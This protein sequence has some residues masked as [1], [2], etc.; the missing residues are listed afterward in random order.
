MNTLRN[1][2]QEVIQDIQHQIISGK[3]K[4]LDKLKP[5]R[6]L[7]TNYQASRSVV[8]SAIH[9][10]S[11]KGYV[12]V[13]PR[14]GVVINDFLHNGT[15]DVVKDIYFSDNTELKAVIIK[16]VMKV[17]MMA[18]LE[19]ISLITQ[20][21]A[22]NLAS[23]ETIINQEMNWL[24]AKNKTI[25]AIAELDHLFHNTLIAL[26]GNNV[27]HLVYNSFEAIE[28]ALII[29]FYENSKLAFEV[30]KMH[31][32]LL[33]A[34]KESDFEYAKNLW[35]KVLMQGEDEILKKLKT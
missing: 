10:L 34:L 29:S 6:E 8:N 30:I 4:P 12:S 22:V 15:I 20:N 7:A 17:R 32:M 26:S 31:Q 35:T 2:T 5:L 27:L 28:R 13:I 19:A 18:E 25:Q 14:Q 1:K 21:Q 16:E 11:A 3:L 33:I 23:L 9:V 24:K